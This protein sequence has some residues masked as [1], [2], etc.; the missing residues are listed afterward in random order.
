MQWILRSQVQHAVVYNPRFK[1]CAQFSTSFILCQTALL[2]FIMTE[3]TASQAEDEGCRSVTL[4]PRH[5]IFSICSPAFL[6]TVDS[7]A[8][9]QDICTV[10]P[11]SQVEQSPENQEPKFW[12]PHPSTSSVPLARSRHWRCSASCRIRSV[13][14]MQHLGWAS[15][16][17]HHKSTSV[18]HPEASQNTL[19]VGNPAQTQTPLGWNAAAT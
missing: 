18:A 14:R 19:L 6:S 15:L 8:L 2:F 16:F 13:K 1:I 5:W 3:I 9:Y 11:S 17:L 4:K 10:N 12:G 7:P